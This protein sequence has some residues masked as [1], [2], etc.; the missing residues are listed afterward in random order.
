MLAEQQPRTARS[1]LR[2]REDV[3]PLEESGNAGGDAARMDI[4][5]NNVGI[6]TLRYPYCMK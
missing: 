5:K 2:F 1:G 3:L 4:C 6:V